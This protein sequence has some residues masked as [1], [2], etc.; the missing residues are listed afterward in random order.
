MNEKELM[1][2]RQRQQ[3]GQRAIDPTQFKKSFTELRYAD[4]SPAQ[5]L[6]V[7]LPEAEGCWPVVV[8]VHGG[9]WYF[10]GR[11][12]EC[13]APIFKIVSQ[14]YAVATVDYRLVPDV[15]FPY[16]LYDVKAAVRYLRAHREELQIDTD[17]LVI[18]GNSAGAHLAA[19]AAARGNF[20]EL[21]DLSMGN[22][23]YS[24]QV[25]G[26]LGWYGIYDI[27][28]EHRQLL[29]QYPDMDPN[30][31]DAC[32]T[33]LGKDSAQKRK[34]ASAVQ[35]VTDQFPP[36]LLQQGQS[37]RL[38]SWH[39]AEEFGDR[40]RSRCG[41][42]RVKVEYFPTAGHGDPQFKT[43]ENI[44]RCVR[45]LDSIYYPDQPCPYPRKP[46]PALRFTASTCAKVDPYEAR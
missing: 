25:D 13:I 34:A 28:T 43:D 35:Y 31:E 1:Q 39:Q 15:F 3:A 8:F 16:Q 24:S 2:D 30:G 42:D 4:D 20:P 11:R 44:L 41:E 29:D 9:G 6:D 21:E 32:L 5:V 46:L 40:I 36:T 18:W 23:E 38:V 45:F 26:F 10:G 12:E 14:G 37:D 17:R 19:L 22:A 33:M 27:E 7:F